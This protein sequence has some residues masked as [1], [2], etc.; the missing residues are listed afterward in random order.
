MY[1]GLLICLN[2]LVLITNAG[3]KTTYFGLDSTKKAPQIAARKARL[4][5]LYAQQEAEVAAGIERL[6]DLDRQINYQMGCK[7]CLPPIAPKFIKAAAY[8]SCVAPYRPKSSED[9][10]VDFYNYKWAAKK[11]KSDTK[12][13]AD[14]VKRLSEFMIKRPLFQRKNTWK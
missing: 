10:L 8:Q 1:L 11:N 3:E 2:L 5:A 6:L 7:K 4:A 12:F 9:Q 14:S 13:L